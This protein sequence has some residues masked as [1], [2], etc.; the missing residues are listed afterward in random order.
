MDTLVKANDNRRK[1]RKQPN[2]A[3]EGVVLFRSASPLPS[4][5]F[6]PPPSGW[7][8]V[9]YYCTE[10]GKSWIDRQPVLM[11]V[12]ADGFIGLPVL[13]PGEISFPD[14]LSE[15]VV[16]GRHGRGRVT[17]RAEGK[18]YRNEKIWVQAVR[19]AHAAARRF[20]FEVVKE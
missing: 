6:R 9:R 18:V 17:V 19:E 7:V 2:R 14:C 20:E 5:E 4:V 16:S 3:R 15:G 8:R 10:G 11:W 12:M 13:C 1:K